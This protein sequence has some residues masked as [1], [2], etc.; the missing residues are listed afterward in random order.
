MDVGLTDLVAGALV[1]VGASF[2]LVG[3]WVFVKRSTEDENRR[4]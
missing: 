2:G 4:K 3:L 1:W